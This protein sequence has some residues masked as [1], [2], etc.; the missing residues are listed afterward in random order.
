MLKRN[1]SFVF[2]KIVL[3]KSKNKPILFIHGFYAN[4]GYWLPYLPFFK[5]HKIVLLNLDY[6][7]LLDSNDKIS[8]IIEIIEALNLQN[9]IYAIIG[10]SLGTI[11]SNF[12]NFT[13]VKF[14]FDICHVSHALRIDTEGFVNDILS[15][16][17]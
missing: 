11:I 5:E 6:Y 8:K 13:S 1:T 9:D 12:I 16:I 7:F 3:N 10:H 15:R 17:K 14:H 2:D 4:A